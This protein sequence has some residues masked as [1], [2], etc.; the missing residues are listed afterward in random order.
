MFYWVLFGVLAALCVLFIVRGFQYGW[1]FKVDFVSTILS[2]LLALFILGIAISFPMKAEQNIQNMKSEKQFIEYQCS[3]IDET[4]NILEKLAL[5]IA[6][7]DAYF[8]YNFK[9][10][11]MKK[12]QENYGIL[13]K[14]YGKDLNQLEIKL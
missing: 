9:L 8:Q 14:Y 7:R 13:S 3:L 1:N 5:E 6:V 11:Q 12:S 4:E 10:E 2:G